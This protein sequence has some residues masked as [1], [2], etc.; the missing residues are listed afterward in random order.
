MTGNA[1]GGAG[2]GGGISSHGRL[3]LDSSTV[4]GNTVAGGPNGSA[5]GGVSAGG[6][7]VTIDSS[8]I[9]DNHVG[10]GGNGG[11]LDLGVPTTIT[12]STIAENTAGGQG[13]G[14][15]S[16]VPLQTTIPITINRSA[17]VGNAADTGGG[18]YNSDADVMIADTMVSGNSSVRTAG[19][20]DNALSSARMSITDSIIADNIG[21]GVVNIGQM[22]LSGSTISGNSSL[23]DGGGLEAGYG[24]T[25][26]VNCTISGNTSAT[27]GGGVSL[28][29]TASIELTSVTIT[30]NSANGTGQTSHGG[31]GLASRPTISQGGRVLVRNTLIAGNFTA[32]IGPDAIGEVISLGFNLIGQRDDSLGWVTRDRTGD[33]FAPLDPLLGPLQDN[34]GPTPTHALL[35]GSP[36]VDGGDP[37]LGGSVDQ[38]GTVRFHSG[39]NPPVDIGAFDAG[40]RGNF[41]LV[42]PAEVAAGAPFA[43][44]VIALDRAGHTAS[45][46][47]GTIHFS[48]TD[49]GAV[50]PEDYT[51]VPSDAGVATF[52]VTLSTEGSQQLGVNDVDIP[53][54]QTAASVMVDPPTAPGG[55][56]ADLFFGEADPAGFGLPFP[57]SG[58]KHV[59]GL[60][61]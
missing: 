8:L 34:G 53:G 51:F 2:F 55:F 13:G 9:A 30:G 19:G 44:T 24:D 25:N 31:G 17:I 1:V 7:T 14:V 59:P 11:G 10:P 33:S 57:F 52:T 60:P 54:I 39:F 41:R 46:F 26:V 15:F 23:F 27:I 35:A 36:A 43:I 56:G 37:T 20:L 58:R 4:T 22:T 16:V 12:D 21:S 18:L 40:V 45:T 42:A 29:G 38:R 3:V 49:F 5:G 28:F 48:S 32:S 50:L 61:L 47:T 6:G